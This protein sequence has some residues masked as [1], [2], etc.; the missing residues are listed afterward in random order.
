MPGVRLNPMLRTM[1]KL[2][3]IV[4]R[5]SGGRLGSLM[6]S[7][8]LLLLETTGRESGQPRSVG[9]SYLEQDGRSFVVGSYAG[10]DRGR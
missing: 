3:R 10:E 5:V 6:G 2:Y 7:M 4:L 1:W 9:R 8:K